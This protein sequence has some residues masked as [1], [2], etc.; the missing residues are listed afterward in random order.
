[1]DRV[2]FLKHNEKNVIVEFFNWVSDRHFEIF[3]TIGEALDWLVA[4]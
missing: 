2:R 3:D 1:M 4:Q